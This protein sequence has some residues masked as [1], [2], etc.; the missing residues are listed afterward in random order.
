MKIL[1]IADLHFGKAIHGQSLIDHG[2][3]PYWVERFLELVKQEKP[4]AILIAG[5]VYDRSAPSNEAVELL[6]HMLTELVVQEDAP[7]VMIISGNHDSGRRL[8]FGSRLLEKQN[9]YIAGV[10][11]PE[12]MHVTLEDTYGPVTFWL[13]PYLFPAA[14]NEVLGTECRDYDSAMRAMIA[15]Q[16]IDYSQ[17]NVIVAHQNV[18]AFGAEADRGGS[19]T[20]VG[21]VGGIDYEAF[22]GFDYVALGHIHAAQA[23][24]REEVR[25][26]GSPLCYHFEETRRPKKGPVLLEMT[27]KGE[28]IDIRVCELPVLHEMREVTGTMEEIIEAEKYR[29]NREEYIR[30]ILKEGKRE[31]DTDDSL[32]AFFRERGS[33]VLDISFDF[34]RAFGAE[35]AASTP[36]GPMILKSVWKPIRRVWEG[37]IPGLTFRWSWCITRNSKTATMP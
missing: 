11:K 2:D 5:D 4:E 13:L 9:L 6:D 8:S 31:A 20:M 19:E 29:D 17:R 3:Q 36:D 10:L 22:N 34:S 14:V 33:L 32:R 7:A 23:M 28:P 16:D 21:G 18:L 25:Y 15:A 37:N 26:A 12:I 35:T 24:G 30:V 27:A 1:H